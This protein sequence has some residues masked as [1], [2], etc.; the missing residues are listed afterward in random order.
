MDIAGLCF[1]L[2]DLASR[3]AKE[4]YKASEDARYTKK[5]CLSLSDRLEAGSRALEDLYRHREENI[6]ILKNIVFYNNLQRYVNAATEIKRFIEEISQL[7]GAMKYIKSNSH[8]FK[9][10][11]LVNRYDQTISDL[12]LDVNIKSFKKIQDIQSLME[13]E[14]E[15]MSLVNK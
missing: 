1:P 14:F 7:S 2:F 4:A 12:N 9:V 3:I 5:I 13:M 15:K 6:D 11:Q 10:D 8:R